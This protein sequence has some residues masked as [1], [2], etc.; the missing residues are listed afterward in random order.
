VRAG[1]AAVAEP[2]VVGQEHRDRVA[3]VVKIRRCWTTEVIAAEL[4]DVLLV[5][6]VVG[7]GPLLEQPMLAGGR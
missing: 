5:A 7:F 4:A 2:V 3:M 6:A 1:V